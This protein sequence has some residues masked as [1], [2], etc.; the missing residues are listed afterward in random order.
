LSLSDFLADLNKTAG[1][2]YT[3]ALAGTPNSEVGAR[4]W[5]DTLIRVL[6]YDRGAL[7]FATVNNAV[8]KASQGSRSLDDLLLA[9]LQRRQEKG[10][11]VRAD[12]EEVITQELGQQGLSDFQAMLAGMQVLPASDA[13]GA[14][15]RRITRPLR[16]YE[17]G[18]DS[19]VMAERQ[20]IVRGLVADS[21]AARAGLRNGD[22]I[23]Q[24]FGQ[25]KVQEDQTQTLTVEVRR[26]GKRFTVTYLPRGETVQAYQWERVPDIP[27]SW[28][29]N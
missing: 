23:L 22:E 18:F 24:P 2:Y 28:C 12:W 26:D 25:D 15:F 6:P 27:E 11:I 1:R 21:A 16:R 13:F 9:M 20:R 3:D 7:Y 29:R 19:K 5:S 10:R 8:R 4:F 17:L 14:C